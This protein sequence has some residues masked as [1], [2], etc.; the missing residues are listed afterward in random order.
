LSSVQKSDDTSR[1]LEQGP[2]QKLV[3]STTAKAQRPITSI[4]KMKVGDDSSRLLKC[5]FLHSAKKGKLP[6]TKPCG[7]KETDHGLGQPMNKLDKSKE[8]RRAPVDTTA[9]ITGHNRPG[10]SGLST[11]IKQQKKVK[12][13]RLSTY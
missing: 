2:R 11:I 4:G 7:Q 12:K 13:S 10:L 5:T 3:T 6:G 1:T 8:R 9:S